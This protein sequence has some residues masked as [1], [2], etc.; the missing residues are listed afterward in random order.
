[1]GGGLLRLLGPPQ[2]AT[3]LPAGPNGTRNPA[4][5]GLRDG[6]RAQPSSLASPQGLKS[7]NGERSRAQE[8]IRA[9]HQR[10]LRA[11]H[12]LHQGRPTQS[13]TYSTADAEARISSLSENPPP[14]RTIGKPQPPKPKKPSVRR[15]CSLRKNKQPGYHSQRFRLSR[16]ICHQRG[17][18]DQEPSG[19]S[20]AFPP[21]QD[22]T[23]HP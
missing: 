13:K 16:P 6:D 11:N 15:T 2:P 22:R 12:R 10:F 21:I 8:P 4:A 17:S 19:K 7:R 14:R 5:R 1:M 3:H 20:R 9:K 18:I 23:R